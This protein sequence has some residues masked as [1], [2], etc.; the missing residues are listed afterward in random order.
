MAKKTAAQEASKKSIQKKKQGLIEDKTF[1]L[2]NKNKSKKVQQ[3][4]A[5]VERNVMNSGDPKQRKL[6]E[7]RQKAKI[8]RKAALKQAKE[9]QDALF[10]AALLAVQKKTT[11]NKKDGQVVAQGRDGGDDNGA[12]K[13]GTSRA[14]KMMYQMDAQE[15]SEKLREDV[16]M[17]IFLFLLLLLWMDMCVFVCVLQQGDVRVIL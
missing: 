11:V 15:M 1:G 6:E 2:K 8:E 12:K 13:A 7:Q 3:Q 16:R 5:S 4:I 9:E 17:R 10:G 14:M